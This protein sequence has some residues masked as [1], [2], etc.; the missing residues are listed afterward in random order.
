MHHARP[1]GGLIVLATEQERASSYLMSAVPRPRD[2]GQ[3]APWSPRYLRK[4][5]S[6]C[7]DL[8]G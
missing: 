6:T 4:H 5:A 2:A 1:R 8:L 3:A 7:R